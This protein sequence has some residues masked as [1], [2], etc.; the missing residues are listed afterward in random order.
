MGKI[1]EL[2][3]CIKDRHDY[4][5]KNID[6]EVLTKLRE[7]LAQPVSEGVFRELKQELEKF[8]DVKHEQF[9]DTELYKFEVIV[10]NEV[11]TCLLVDEKKELEMQVLEYFKDMLA[12]QSNV[13]R[14][15]NKFIDAVVIN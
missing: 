11:F 5:I 9:L 2:G 14:E 1:D 13:H 7:I 8:Y 10:P 4:Y 12:E 15:C 3:C 6:G